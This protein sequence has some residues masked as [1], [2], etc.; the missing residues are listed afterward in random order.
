MNG[1]EA[2]SILGDFY[3]KN[4]PAK[5]IEVK[6][7]GDEEVKRTYDWELNS[8]GLPTCVY[9]HEISSDETYTLEFRY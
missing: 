3:F 8:A 7:N 2:S 5:V 1:M 9:W 6:A 4:L